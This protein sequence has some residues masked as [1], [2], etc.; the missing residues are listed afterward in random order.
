[1][2]LP[3]LAAAPTFYGDLGYDA[4]PLV[5]KSPVAHGWERLDPA[6]QWAA[7]PAGANVGLRG[8]GLA[9]AAFIDCDEKTRPGTFT[10]VQ[11][12]L[13]GLGYE[14]GS[15]PV[16]ATVNDGRHVYASLL[17][18]LPGDWRALDAELGAGEL[19]YGPGA[20]AVAAPSAIGD[21]AYH[22]IAGD[23]RQPARLTVADVLALVANKSLTAITPKARVSSSAWALLRGVGVDRY[24]SRSDAEQAI[25]TMLVN[26]GH[27][28]PAVARLFQKNPAAGKFA[29]L[30]A[31]GGTAGLRWLRVSFDKA[32]KWAAANVSEGRELGR[33]ALA[34]GEVR[35]WTGRTGSIDR[36]VFLAHAHIAARAGKLAYGAACRELAELAG[37]SF[38]TAI[39]ATKRLTDAQLLALHEAST[40]SFPNTYRLLV[41]NVATFAM[42]A[43]AHN[44]H[45]PSLPPV[46]ECASYANHDAF[47]V[48]GLGK[49]AGEV[50]RALQDGPAT[51]ARLAEKTGRKRRTVSA[52]LGRMARIVE[53]VT[54]EI[55]AGLA[56][57]RHDDGKWAV[58]EGVDLDR[59]AKMLG[60]AG[61]GKRQREGHRAE[62]RA[63]GKALRRTANNRQC[64]TGATHV[65]R[66]ADYGN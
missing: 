44:L 13:F 41:P 37:V 26:S 28:F 61:K 33:A 39:A 30:N 50:W 10:K 19:R 56:L 42:P 12:Y 8:G 54:G 22:L 25:V 65:A 45:T 60:T 63:H 47:R 20:V 11:N 15:Y 38:R 48:G 46:R 31:S 35:A 34:W 14:P 43:D 51:V 27:D 58:V 16:V 24:N 1:V 49:A 23:L 62:R 3:A 6:E 53:P 17:G 36:A 40:P 55:M 7:A 66:R 18:D 21:K 57:V 2:T 52:A 4:V 9:L 5:G 29:E 59:V 32:R 64:L